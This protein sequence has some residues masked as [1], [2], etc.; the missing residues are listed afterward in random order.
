MRH[1]MIRHGAVTSY[2]HTAGSKEDILQYSEQDLQIDHVL[3]LVTCLSSAQSKRCRSK[4][5]RHR[6]AESVPVGRIAP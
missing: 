2:D 6:F 1:I 5:L 3:Y 4:N